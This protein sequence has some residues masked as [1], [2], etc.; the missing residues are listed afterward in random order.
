MKTMGEFTLLHYSRAC[1]DLLCA[2]NQEAY[3]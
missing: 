3:L 1:P 2:K